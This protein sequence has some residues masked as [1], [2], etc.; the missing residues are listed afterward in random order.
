MRRLI[1]DFWQALAFRHAISRLAMSF[2]GKVIR[3][4]SYSLFRAERSKFA[5]GN[6]VLETLPQYSIFG[7]MALID[8]APRSATAIAASNA[9][10]VP[11]SEKQFLFLISNTPYFALNVMRVMA[12]RLRAANTAL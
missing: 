12:Q 4:K 9:K 6:R 7:E 1:F 2:S 3:R 11:V 5:L 8:N 10:L